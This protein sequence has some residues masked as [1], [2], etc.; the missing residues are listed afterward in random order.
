MF[1]LPA[2]YLFLLVNIGCSSSSPCKQVSYES[3][4]KKQIKVTWTWDDIKDS[5]N[6]DASLSCIW[7]L[8]PYRI[9]M[10]YEGGDQTTNELGSSTGQNIGPVSMKVRELK[11][12]PGTSVWIFSTFVLNEKDVS[13][14]DPAVVVAGN[15]S[16]F[17]PN[18]DNLE[19]LPPRSVTTIDSHDHLTY[20][21]FS[22]NLEEC[23]RLLRS[24]NACHQAVLKLWAGSTNNKT[25]LSSVG[26]TE[27]I[28]DT[29]DTVVSSKGKLL[30]LLDMSYTSAHLMGS[31]VAEFGFEYST[32]E[33]DSSD[34]M[35]ATL[36]GIMLLGFVGCIGTMILMCIFR[37]TPGNR[38][39]IQ[40]AIAAHQLEIDRRRHTQ[41]SNEGA[42]LQRIQKMT[43]LYSFDRTE[44]EK[45][46]QAMARAG[47]EGGG[48]DCTICLSDVLVSEEEE[49]EE[50]E[51]NGT[52]RSRCRLLPC[53]HMFHAKC[54]ESWLKMK[55]QCPMCKLDIVD[56]VR[57]YKHGPPEGTEEGDMEVA[58]RAM[59]YEKSRHRFTTFRRELKEF[60][61]LHVAD[62]DIVENEA[63]EAGEG[64]TEVEMVMQQRQPLTVVVPVANTNVLINESET[65]FV[66]QHVVRQ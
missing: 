51:E 12:P 56:T 26:L 28:W 13:A 4:S 52:E 16:Y 9:E 63:E 17:R 15:Y 59:M 29:S 25:T 43:L 58:R 48:M 49:E 61:D 57:W 20:T 33:E 54:V 44:V 39:R 32:D 38:N 31:N 40:D 3:S 7:A 35:L 36:F 22:I 14:S 46:R 60:E 21:G 50:E 41:R 47:C 45:V 24:K 19:G 55:K 53:S 30:V 5:K 27:S 62:D 37:G 10:Q 23:E 65:L 8:D 1:F 42:T 64:K 11:L 18:A 6:K 66:N 2:F 34:G